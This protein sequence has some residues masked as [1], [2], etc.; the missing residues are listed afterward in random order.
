M[1]NFLSTGFSSGAHHWTPI[2][3]TVRSPWSPDVNSRGLWTKLVCALMCPKHLELS[4]ANCLSKEWLFIMEIL[5]MAYKTP[6]NPAV[7]DYRT[8]C[9][10]VGLT[11]QPGL[12]NGIRRS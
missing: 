6:P 11:P 3:G 5:E 7:R 1:G 2:S 8:L 9:I 12:P 10:L 4:L